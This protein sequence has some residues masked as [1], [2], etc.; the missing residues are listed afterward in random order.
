M[1]KT[2]ELSRTHKMLLKQFGNVVINVEDI[3]ELYLNIARRTALN[4]AKTHS[5]PFPCFR[6]GDSNKSPMV[7]HISDFSDYIDK[8][9]EEEKRIWKSFQII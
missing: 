7:C 6:L 8:R 4:L 3:A 2:D 9:Q 5:L 1:K